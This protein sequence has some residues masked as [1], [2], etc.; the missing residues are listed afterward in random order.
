MK[1]TDFKISSRL[2]Y[3]FKFIWSEFFWFCFVGPL[4]LR[5][6]YGFWNYVYR[7]ILKGV[8][9]VSVYMWEHVHIQLFLSSC[10][11]LV[12]TWFP[13]TPKSIIKSCV[14]QCSFTPTLPCVRGYITDPRSKPQNGLIWMEK[15]QK[16][17]QI[18]A[19]AGV[20]PMREAGRLQLNGKSAIR[21]RYLE[22][23]LTSCAYLRCS[24]CWNW[25]VEQGVRKRRE[26]SGGYDAPGKDKSHLVRVKF[27]WWIGKLK[28]KRQVWVSSDV[29][30]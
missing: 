9:R 6:L 23:A 29:F 10:F 20:Q 7:I 18:P 13:R 2:L 25:M 19:M 24:W 14:V 11:A 21:E 5:C 22:D 3:Y 16:Q 27:I 1:C 17:D 26:Q 4:K 12:S 28:L 8:G 15:M 30:S